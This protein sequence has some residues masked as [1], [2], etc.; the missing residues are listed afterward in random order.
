[1]VLILL[2]WL[3]ISA[4]LVTVT[5][6]RYVSL[7]RDIITLALLIGALISRRRNGQT[8][9]AGDVERLVVWLVVWS[10][11]SLAFIT[12]DPSAW[13]WSA[14]YSLAPLAVF[15]ALHSFAVTSFQWRRLMTIWLSWT[16]LLFLFGL[17]MVFIIPPE[18]LIAWGYSST[19]AIGNGQW[20][21]GASLP[22]YQAVAGGIPRLQATLTGPIQLA[23]FGAIVLFMLRTAARWQPTWFWQKTLFVLTVLMIL[24]TFSRSVWLA[25]IIIGAVAAFRRLRAQGLRRRDLAAWGTVTLVGVVATLGLIFMSPNNEALRFS[26]GRILAREGSDS[27]HAASITDSLADWKQVGFWGLGFGRS[28]P[29][30]I[31]HAAANPQAPLPRFVDNSYLRWWEELGIPG[32]ALFLAMIWILI[33][34]LRLAGPIGRNLAG[35]GLTLALA[36]LLTDM[37]AEAVPLYTFLILAALWHQEPSRDLQSVNVGRF[38]ISA[39]DLPA[40]MR[41]LSGWTK[42]RDPHAVVTLNPEMYVAA[43]QHKAVAEALVQADLITADGS[44]LVAAAD[45]ARQINGSKIL[46]WRWLKVVWLPAAWLWSGLRLIFAPN[47]LPLSHVTGADLVSCLINK[48]G[49]EKPRVALIGSTEEV[50]EKIKYNF[51]IEERGMTVVLARPAPGYTTDT[52]PPADVTKFAK[53]LSPLHADYLFVAFGVPRQERFIIENRRTLGVPVM[54]GVSGAFDSVLAGTVHRAPRLLQALHIEWLW[55]L[56]LQPKRIG[57]IW[58]ATWRFVRV[59]SRD[60]IQS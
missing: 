22:A 4:F 10:L 23:G 42:K 48:T 8:I 54:I 21:G 46:R 36:S 58:T 51:S 33:S 57:R 53:L 28:G 1:M 11:I 39:I 37:W 3:P 5:G 59:A 40:T 6:W 13:M 26:V 38:T 27:E 16:G 12:R 49:S 20:V 32:V 35:A 18:T 60:I 34:E 19:V 9:V 2:M 50:M 44:G 25:L 45:V 17:A 29:G 43:A 24:G 7:I 52:V 41:R 14:R 15:W 55:R 47:R 31:Q 30:S 56:I